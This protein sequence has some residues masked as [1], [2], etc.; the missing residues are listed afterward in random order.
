[1][2]PPEIHPLMKYLSQPFVFYYRAWIRLRCKCFSLLVSG[3]FAHF[4]KEASLMYPI[5]LS[6]EKRISIGDRVYVGAGSWLQS[7]PDGANKAVAIP[8]GSGNQHCRQCR[9]FGGSECILEEDVL[10]RATFTSQTTCTSTRRRTVP[11]VSQ[12]L[13]KILLY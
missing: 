1:M 8:L 9:N 3:A 5:R 10:L 4:G 13:D 11:I 12:G 6:G 7:L 2:R